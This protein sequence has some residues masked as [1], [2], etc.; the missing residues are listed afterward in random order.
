MEDSLLFSLKLSLQ[1]ASVAT[2]LIIATGFIRSDSETLFDST[3][4]INI[5]SH[6]RFLGYVFQDLALFPHMTVRENILYGAKG[7]EKS[8]REDSFHSMMESFRLRGLETKMPSE[9]SGGQKQRVALARSLIR[10]PNA[11]LLD[12]PFSALDN[13]MRLEMRNFLRNTQRIF[14]IPIVLVTHDI[15]D[16]HSLA[17]KVVTYSCGNIVQTSFPSHKHLYEEVESL[18]DHKGSCDPWQGL[19]CRR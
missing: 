6:R 11:L 14:Q 13:E 5:P 15:G 12:E 8:E 7:L 3:L 17:D 9:I 1:V 18:I 4:K 2:V 19:Y 16:L 10:R